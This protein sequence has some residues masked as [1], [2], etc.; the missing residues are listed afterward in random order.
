MT[1][2]TPQTLG[3]PVPRRD[4]AFRLQGFL[5]SKS[6]VAVEGS[7]T[8]LV[9]HTHHAALVLLAMTASLALV[10]CS[11]EK[12]VSTAPLAAAH[13]TTSFLNH[14]G[15]FAQAT[16]LGGPIAGLTPAEHARFE[17][18]LDD[19]QEIE[20]IED[21][22]GPVFN[23][24]GCVVCHDAPIGGTNGRVETR[25]GRWENGRFDDLDELGGSLIQDQ[26]IGR[27]RAG[28]RSFF[29][30]VPEVVP[31]RANTKASRVTT[32]LFGLG[33]VIRP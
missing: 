17:A 11:R 28:R 22:L 31:R 8:P 7:S 13:D 26:A 15:D 21:G 24:A 1:P 25:F 9:S 27:V 16:T 5:E 20:T 30:F 6:P 33:L 18:G 14:T 19:F 12:E 10:G 2:P 3:A 32:P 4:P 23:E 29:T